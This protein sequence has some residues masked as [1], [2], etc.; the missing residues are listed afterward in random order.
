MKDKHNTIKIKPNL[1]SERK[2][3][4]NQAIDL[5]DSYPDNIYNPPDFVYADVHGIIR[6]KMKHRSKLGLFF[7]VTCLQDVA[8]VIQKAQTID[9]KDANFDKEYIPY[10]SDYNSGLSDFADLWLIIGSILYFHN[11]VFLF[12]LVA[13]YVLIP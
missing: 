6:V 3:F 7:E 10:D 1:W 13:Y 4:L 9:R 11:F 12:L 5:V 2:R 8:S